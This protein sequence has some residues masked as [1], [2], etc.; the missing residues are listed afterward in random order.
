MAGA[1]VIVSAIGILLLVLVGY[2]LV[3][4]T[5]ASGNMIA[6]AQKDMT[7][8]R[9]D[10][11]NTNITVTYTS[12][13]YGVQCPV[14]NLNF[15]IRNTG[16]TIIDYQKLNMVIMTTPP[17]SPDYINGYATGDWQLLGIYQDQYGHGELVN[18]N[19]WDPGEYVAGYICMDPHPTDLYVFTPNGAIGYRNV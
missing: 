18:P 2:V 8:L 7:A 3:G 10:Q 11:L 13:N 6:S 12:Q 1:V 16:N 5:L 15:T 4:N 19:L 9:E 14:H 17:Y